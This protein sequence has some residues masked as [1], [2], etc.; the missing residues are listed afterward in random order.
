MGQAKPNSRTNIKLTEKAII[1]EFMSNSDAV[2]ELSKIDVKQRWI[3]LKALIKSNL[4]LDI[5]DSFAKTLSKTEIVSYR[6][7]DLVTYTR[8]DPPKKQRKPSP[9]TFEDHDPNDEYTLT[10]E[11]IDEKFNYYLKLM[12]PDDEWMV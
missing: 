2:K 11:E 10:D 1:Y 7:G 6:T 4:D 9:E 3:H 5:K 8:I 12:K